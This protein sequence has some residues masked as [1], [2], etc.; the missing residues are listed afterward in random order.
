MQ[1]MLNGIRSRLANQLTRARHVLSGYDPTGARTMM[2][3]TGMAGEAFQNIELLLPY[4]Y[5][6]VPAG[7]TADALI[8]QVN[9]HRDHKI[10]L[11][12]DDPALR[13]PGLQA[14]EFGLRDARGQQVVF[15]ADHIEV[16]TPQKLVIVSTGDID[17]NVSQGN[18]NVNVAQGNVAVSA[19][20]GAITLSAE[21]HRITA[22][23]NELG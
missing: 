8:F 14:G 12:A 13:I 17:L 22:N 15:H 23:G 16:T 3:V 6:A 11:A 21:A 18:L 1:E 2:Q 10:G 20:G 5:S 19:S 4:G 7:N 9:G